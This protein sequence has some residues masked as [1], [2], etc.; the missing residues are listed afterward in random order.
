[1]HPRVENGRTVHVKV[2]TSKPRGP[3]TRYYDRV[4]AR[5]NL[6]QRACE[7]TKKSVIAKR[8]GGF[9]MPGSMN[10]HRR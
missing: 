7:E 10:P 5:L 8:A 6:R 4:K 1:M 3:K 2:D 9:K